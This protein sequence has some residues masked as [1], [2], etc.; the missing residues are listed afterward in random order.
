MHSS[1]APSYRRRI[2]YIFPFSSQCHTRNEFS[3]ANTLPVKAQAAGTPILPLL[4]S[5]ASYLENDVATD[6]T[7]GVL[8]QAVSWSQPHRYDAVRD[9]HRADV[10]EQQEA[11]CYPYTHTLPRRR[12]PD[13]GYPNCAREGWGLAFNAAGKLK[14]KPPVG[15]PFSSH[16][17]PFTPHYPPIPA[18]FTS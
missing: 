12:L 13:H 6:I 4:S 5:N 11:V 3:K 15:V 9:L 14:C 18:I 17:F 2:R 7:R 16:L 8:S 1:N 10:R